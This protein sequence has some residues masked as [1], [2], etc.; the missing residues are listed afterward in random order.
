M[1]AFT[2]SEPLVGEVIALRTFRVDESGL[3]LPLY[4]DRS[5]YDGPNC[6]TCAPPTGEAE[7]NDHQVASPAC[8]CGFYAFGTPEAASRYR[9]SRY[10]QAVV[11]CWGSVVGGTLGVRAE[12]ARIEA[13]WLGPGA[14]TWV[15][16]RVGLTY[17]SARIY[18][19]RDEMLAEHP[20]SMLPCYAPPKPPSL[21]RRLAVPVAATVLIALG[22]V[23]SSAVHGV[24]WDVWL[25]VAVAIGV[26]VGWLV[27]GSRAIG[28]VALAVVLAGVLAWFAAPLFGLAGWL[29]RLPAM[30]AVFMSA[31]GYLAALRPG[32]FP[33]V[34]APAQPRFRGVVV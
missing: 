12:R 27:V 19:D 7:R 9:N 20:L 17:P 28:H 2:G 10:V 21:P 30:R 34:R 32:Y 16:K 11:A 29:L 26:F 13:I 22:L 25:G 24:L 6:A 1:P 14:P 23:P 31:G 18:L 5:W 4:S 3:L 33:I 15:V 8:D